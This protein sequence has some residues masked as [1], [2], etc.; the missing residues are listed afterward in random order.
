MTLSDIVLP[1]HLLILAFVAWNT[2]HADH[3]G[4]KW[5]RG[6]INILNKAE[7]QKY[8][9]R[10]WFGLIGMI[11]T[12]LIMFLPLREYL[13]TRPQFYVKMAFV[14][15]LIINGFFIGRLQNIATTKWFKETTPQEKI[16]LFISGAVSTIA[17]IGAAI[18]GLYLIPD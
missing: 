1:I 8:H 10:V 6:Q 5:I 2:F 18:G 11:V 13:L 7:V 3:L 17:W 4:F 16:A 12:G 15:T 9:R 14:L